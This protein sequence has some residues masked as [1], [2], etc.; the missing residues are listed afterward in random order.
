MEHKKEK[1]VS[2]IR[3][4]VKKKDIFLSFDEDLLLE[5][6]RLLFKNQ[7]TVQQFLTFVLYKI[8][9]RHD[10]VEFLWQELNDYLLKEALSKE[11]KEDILKIDSRNLYSYFESLDKR[12]AE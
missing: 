6:K 3:E 11:E 1:N 12:K 4:K 8:A 2:F 7:T 5:A 10:N 9:N